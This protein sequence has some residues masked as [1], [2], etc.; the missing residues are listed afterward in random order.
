M[1][2]LKLTDHMGLDVRHRGAPERRARRVLPP[3]PA[4]APHGPGGQAG[5]EERWRILQVL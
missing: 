5:Q 2:P 1:G 3:S 4:A